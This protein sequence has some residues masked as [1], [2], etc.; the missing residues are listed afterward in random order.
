MKTK[1]NFELYKMQ[2][3][4]CKTFA[5]PRRLIIIQELRGGEKSV[6]ELQAILDIAQPVVSHHLSILKTKGVVS[7]KR[8]G[9]NVYYQLTNPKICEACDIIHEILVHNTKKSHDLTKG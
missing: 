2:A 5:E 3:E 8:R 6:G 9:A 7:A 1:Y 4:L